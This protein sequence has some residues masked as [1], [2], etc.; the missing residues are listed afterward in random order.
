MVEEAIFRRSG[1]ILLSRPYFANALRMRA[2]V[3]S[4]FPLFCF[5]SNVLWR[6]LAKVTLV[7]RCACT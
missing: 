2:G 5:N 7:S 4:T 6:A 1:D 3:F